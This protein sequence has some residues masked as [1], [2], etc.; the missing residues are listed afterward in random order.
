MVKNRRKNGD[1]YWVYANVTPI[2]DKGEM[3]GYMSVRNKGTR[4]QINEAENYYRRLREGHAKGFTIRRGRIVRTGLIGKLSTLRD[5]SLGLR[6]GLSMGFMGL[7]IVWLG[8]A[9][10]L[11][12]SRH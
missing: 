3:V 4:E 6:I 1:Y 10:F 9:G 12:Q 2:Y 7:L 5:M 11:R 8:A